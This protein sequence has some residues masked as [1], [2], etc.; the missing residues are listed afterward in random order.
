MRVEKGM[1]VKRVGGAAIILG[2]GPGYGD[3]LV[4]DAHVLPGT[5]VTS[6]VAMAIMQ[7][8]N[9]T[10]EP[11]VTIGKANTALGTKPAPLVGTFSSRGPNR[12]EPN[13]LKVYCPFMFGCSS[14]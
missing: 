4:V 10:E 13:I 3:E 7:Y 11:T 5:A 6:D 8:I 2:N 9:S 1:E 12:I 14:E